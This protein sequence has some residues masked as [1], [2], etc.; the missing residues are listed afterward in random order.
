MS[1]KRPRPEGESNGN[2]RRN[3]KKNGKPKGKKPDPA[4]VVEDP[5]P[6]VEDPV[7]AAEEPEEPTSPFEGLTLKQRAF[8]AAFSVCGQLSKAKEI[9][10]VGFWS[11]HGWLKS[12]PAY[13]EAYDTAKKMASDNIESEAIRRAMHGTRKLRFYKNKMIMVPKLDVHGQPVV[14]AH[15]GGWIMEPY[16]EI[17][18]SDSLMNSVLKAHKPDKYRD[19]VGFE[20]HLHTH[21][22]PQ[23]GPDGGVVAFLRDRIINAGNAQN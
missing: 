23:Q 14:D 4:P 17:E 1:E 13:H 11:H 10:G 5:V 9:A 8:L 12:T 7:I 21:T 20:S 19:K 18:Y 16:I 2:G 3:G 22:H 15:T 6:V